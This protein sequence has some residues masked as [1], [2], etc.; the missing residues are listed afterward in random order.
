PFGLL[1]V[2]VDRQRRSL[3]DIVFG[4]RVIYARP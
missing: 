1:W 3:H 4:S 2:A